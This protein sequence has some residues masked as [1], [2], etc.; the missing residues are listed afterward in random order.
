[1]LINNGFFKTI[2]EVILEMARSSNHTL[3][4]A[5]AT[6]IFQLYWRNRLWLL[7]CTSSNIFRLHV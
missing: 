4:Y 2:Q 1:L 5:A 7:F 3:C 6:S